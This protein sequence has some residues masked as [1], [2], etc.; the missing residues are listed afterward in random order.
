MINLFLL[1]R[2]AEGISLN[3]TVQSETRRSDKLM[4]SGEE[5]EL[6]KKWDI[7]CIYVEMH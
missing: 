3:T 1:F 7:V 4:M 5:K 6:N 2:N